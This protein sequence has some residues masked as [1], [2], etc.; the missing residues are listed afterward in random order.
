MENMYIRSRSA[1]VCL[2]YKTKIRETETLNTLTLET[3]H[4]MEAT[5]IREASL[6]PEAVQGPDTRP[7]SATAISRACDGIADASVRKPPRTTVVQTFP[8]R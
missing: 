3:I 6:V 4:I 2:K 8:P 5:W 7:W 1:F